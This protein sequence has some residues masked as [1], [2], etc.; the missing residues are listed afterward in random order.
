MNCP[1]VS[2]SLHTL[3]HEEAWITKRL[4]NCIQG[5]LHNLHFYDTVLVDATKL[6]MITGRRE[7]LS[8]IGSGNRSE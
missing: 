2:D 1:L 8:L 5:N 3:K 4:Y 6:S 7:S